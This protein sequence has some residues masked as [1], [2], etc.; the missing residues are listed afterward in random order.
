VESFI[1]K[2]ESAPL[3]LRLTVARRDRSGA[4]VRPGRLHDARFVESHGALAPRVAGVLRV[5]ASGS[6][7]L[8]RSQALVRQYLMEDGRIA[9]EVGNAGLPEEQRSAMLRLVHAMRLVNTRNRLSHA[10]LNAVVARQSAFLASLDARSLIPLR[11]VELAAA[12]AAEADGA[13]GID[14]SRMSRMVRSMSLLLPDRRELPLQDLF[15]GER[16]LIE[17]HLRDVLWVERKKVAAG[18]LTVPL[19]DHA[20]AESVRSRTGLRCSRRTVAYAR[21]GLGI[22]CWR[23][24]ARQGCYLTATENFAELYPL[25][26]TTVRTVVPR[27]P[28]VYE[29]RLAEGAI[30]YPLGACPVFYL[31][32]ARDLRKRLSDH[33]GRNARNRGIRAHV[34]DRDVLFRFL[35][36]RQGWRD[37]ERR[38]YGRFAGTFGQPPRCNESR[39]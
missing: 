29:L 37:E 5:G 10:V 39:P 22:P 28:G 16:S 2:I 15:P 1:K 34:A 21:K 4:P 27:S 38:V 3:F 23:E 36:M 6:Q 18:K 11:Q 13:P 20:L 8:H 14:P 17:A 26:R 33:L 30:D 12:L 32:S 7:L 19:A 25:E 35:R 31:G 24:R 9:A